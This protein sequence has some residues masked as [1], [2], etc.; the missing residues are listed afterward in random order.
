[1]DGEDRTMTHDSID[2]AARDRL[3]HVI[4]L[5]RTRYRLRVLLRGLLVMLG[6]A[7][8]LLLLS[9][10]LLEQFR[11]VPAAVIGVRIGFYLVLAA[12]AFRFLV[13]PLARRPGDEQ[14]ALYIE[15]HEP[16]LGTSIVSAVQ[17]GDRA[18]EG[19]S[20]ALVR[21][22]IEAA[23]ERAR[24][25]DDGRRIEA[26]P[27]R[28][29][30]LGLAGV[31]AVTLAVALA[32][33][34]FVRHT[35]GVLF[36]PWGSAEAAAPYAIGVE[37]G[38]AVVA[39]GGDQRILARLRNFEAEVVRIM[40]RSADTAAWE[41]LP[42]GVAPAGGAYLA[43]LFDLERPT[44]YYV[45]A[46]GVRS[47]TYRLD[48][49]D[50]PYTRRLDLEYRFP[51]YTGLA[52]QTIE[53]GGDVA[54]LRGTK[55]HLMVTPTMRAAAGRVVIEG[56][57]AVPLAVDS[58]GM[59]HGEF[60]VERDGFYRIEMDAGDGTM[61]A[62]S[63][64]Y[65]IEMLPDRA[66]SVEI[67]RPGRDTRVT[68]LEEV[69]VEARAEDDY[70]VARLELVYSVN[71]GPE[72]TAVLHGG[73]ARTEI[74]AGHTLFLEE[75]GL[76]PGDIVSYYA[77][78]SDGNPYGGPN[79]AATDIYFL[80]VRPFDREYRE[81]EQQGMP[82][83]AQESPEGLSEQQREIVSATFK[84]AR[85]RAQTPA[86][87][88]RENLATITLAQGR[89]RDRVETLA[90]QMQERGVASSDSVLAQIAAE[91]PRAAE[92]MRAA[93]EQLNRREAQQ[94][95]PPEQKALQH[96][97]RAEAAF[98]EVQIAR[99]NPQGG[100]GGSTQ[101]DVEELADLFE[102]ENDRQ[103][104]QYETVQR[105][106]E[107]Q[108]RAES[109]EVLERLKQLASRQQQENERLRREAERLQQPGGGS[110]GGGS[111]RRLAAEADSLARQLERL[112]REQ[113]S[114]E[115]RESARRLQ[116]AADAMRRSA[117]R[118]NQG[119]AA[120]G[121]SALE[122][123]EE[124]RRTL[125]RG[126]SSRLER[127]AGAAAERA[128]RLAE[129]Q[130]RLAAEAGRLSPEDAAGRQRI[131]RDKERLANEV[132]QI[133][134][135]LD[136]AA[137][138]ARRDHP[139][140][141]RRLQRAVT[142]LRDRRVREKI[143]YSRR[144]L[145]NPSEGA[146]QFE[147]GITDNLTELRDSV[148]AAAGTIGEPEGR[149][150][151]RAVE[152]ARALSRG[153]ESLAERM[154]AAAGREAGA[155]RGEPG[156]PEGEP[157][158]QQGEP[159]GSPSEGAPRQGQAGGQASPNGMQGTTEGSSRQYAR[160]LRQRRLDA[161][162]LRRDLARQGLDVRELDRVITGMRD[163]EGSAALG[164]D[165]AAVARLRDE[166]AEGLKDFEFGLRRELR[167]P[168]EDRPRLGRQDEVPPE[169]R[170]L[171]EKYYESLAR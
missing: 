87:E 91:L 39:R 150:A 152:R 8:L 106:R 15:E 81:A 115:L 25:V 159:A 121:S 18:P 37:P 59:L 22:L 161:E 14:V 126:N 47:P 113:P 144:L 86:S 29:L 24:A 27:L 129:E 31:A 130:R 34:A 66:P 40:I 63:L 26:R 154:Q 62:A 33:P 110:G 138:D 170:E 13:A 153:V 6:G 166:V 148:Q 23:V 117:A 140:A 116:E 96:L 74:S 7:F 143:D 67:V 131:A 109:D 75:Y 103:Q 10:F 94:A 65:A 9:A 133:E 92:A 112:A 5:V 135:Q 141:S 68:S 45:E 44:D 104:N 70:G 122:A 139:D 83:E 158:G 120:Q 93:E 119:G 155:Q 85:D 57:D 79:R 108:A 46:A 151:E 142:E 49:R 58:A 17:H 84:S 11:F 41:E 51:R 99:G 95:L 36:N 76:E 90:R 167:G 71:G 73:R 19:S 123:L 157:G 16:S 77:R 64:E 165:A 98:R 88:F 164:S 169:Y 56:R 35:L 4:R 124:A 160:E 54:A 30:P 97:L 171:V 163:L 53:N 42:M 3:H 80:Q 72:Q 102:L 60:S 78:A 69:F 132:G 137:R 89:L 134:E 168:D 55:V 21:R 114:P 2:S 111:Q 50:L 146:R 1:M 61:V 156:E 28:R 107:E 38:N 127:E 147:E 128:E 20:P 118:A 149:S 136:R 125:E 32:G 12:L 43:H 52:P 145:G 100:S 48:V 162:Q 82:G 105:G 101:S